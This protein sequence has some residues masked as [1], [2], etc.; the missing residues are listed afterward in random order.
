M[1]LTVFRPALF[2]IAQILFVRS[3]GHFI[4]AP[5]C[6]NTTVGRANTR[7]NILLPAR[8]Y[9]PS[10]SSHRILAGA[11][12]SSGYWLTGV[13]SNLLEVCLFLVIFC[14]QWGYVL[15]LGLGYFCNICFVGRGGRFCEYKSKYSRGA[16]LRQISSKL[17]LREVVSCIGKPDKCLFPYHGDD[18]LFLV[19]FCLQWGYV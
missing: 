14:L 17:V 16:W 2:S 5:S 8:Y 4:T 6:S 15:L 9:H 19:I 18:D 13:G 11:R 7:I 12:E 10:S 1:M 3:V